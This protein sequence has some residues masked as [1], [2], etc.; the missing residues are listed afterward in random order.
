MIDSVKWAI[1]INSLLSIFV[2]KKQP[3]YLKLN[4]NTTMNKTLVKENKLKLKDKKDMELLFN[5]E[6][7]FKSFIF[8]LRRIFYQLEHKPLILTNM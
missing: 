8:H 4:L 3:L 1:A 6:V 2:Y 7:D 5:N